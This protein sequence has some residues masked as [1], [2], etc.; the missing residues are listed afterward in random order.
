M[1]AYDLR[2]ID[3]T[4]VVR[5]ARQGETLMLLDGREITL[6]DSVMV[7]ADRSKV[8]GLAGIMGGEH[9]GIGAGTTDVLLE[10]AFFLP[11]AIAGRARRYGLVTDAS[12]RFERGVDPSGQERAIERAT[13]LICDI[14]GGVPGP[15]TVTE[16][17]E[18]LPVRR[19]VDFRPDRARSVIGEAIADAE[20]NSILTGLGLAVAPGTEA[21]TVTPPAWRF[22]I[23]MEEDLI[24]EVARVFGFTRVAE[25]EQ[26]VRQPMPSVT[27]TRLSVDAAADVLVQR[28]YFEAISYSFV[29][30]ELQL[31]LHPDQTALALANP[32]S[33]DLAA[34]RLS[35]WPGLVKALLENQRRQ[36]AR[37]RLFETGTKFRFDDGQLEEVQCLA[38]IA[39]GAAL[40]EQ[41][42]SEARELDFFDMKADVM[43]VVEGTGQIGN[44]RYEAARHP[45]LHPGQSA[46][47]LRDGEAVGWLGRLHPQI[48]RKL[49]L[50]YS[51]LV[52]ELEAAAALAASVPQYQEISRFPAVRR[53]IAV[54][55]NENMSVAALLEIVRASAGDLLQGTVV[56]DIY[57]GKGIASGRKSVA[58]GLNL[59]DISRTL[60]EDEI[61]AVVARVS[62]DLEQK[63]G[64]TIRDK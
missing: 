56:F 54:V 42:G 24:E 16:S 33:A 13:Q 17:P 41:W 10:V 52:F 58:M 59:Q 35:L 11:D 22:D 30:P 18:E 27:E 2:E 25:R 63:C 36:Q 31:L 50:T 8:I 34:M 6:D 3:D 64:A 48:E 49:D 43:A 9:S 28:G 19:A 44:F 46:R 4:V 14:A 61:D 39:S 21:W 45:A 15:T 5:R 23:S 29:D 51:A 55:V 20:M 40:P 60:A 37:V 26:A 1:H 38:G 32:I 62:N 12:Q 7:I 57:R 53:D 47:I